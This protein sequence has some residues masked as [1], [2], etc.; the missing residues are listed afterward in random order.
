MPKLL[1]TVFAFK[2][3]PLHAKISTP[4]G[5]PIPDKKVKELSSIVTKKVAL[6]CP[7][8]AETP[9]T[10]DLGRPFWMPPYNSRNIQNSKL[11]CHDPSHEL[12]IKLVLV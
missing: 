1:K 8:W 7:L 3:N 11:S 12:G 6:L 2:F 4:T 5:T 10:P 9:L